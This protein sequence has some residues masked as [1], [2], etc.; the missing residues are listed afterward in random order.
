M[1]LLLNGVKGEN[2]N[3]NLICRFLTGS[4]IR[5]IGDEDWA[6]K[7]RMVKYELL[8]KREGILIPGFL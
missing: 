5:N 2:S 7:K 8:L 1:L 4:T 3:G 6:K